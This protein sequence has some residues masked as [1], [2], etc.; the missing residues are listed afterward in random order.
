[1]G[2]QQVLRVAACVLLIG[3]LASAAPRKRE[4]ERIAIV[5]LGPT[6]DGVRGK[7]AAAVV[8]G[9]LQ[10]V[11]GD[12]V[13]DALAG[14]DGDKDAAALAAAMVEAKDKFGAL[15]CPEATA[16]AKSAIAIAAARQAAGIAVPELPR[17]WTYVL[18]CA[19]R[20]GDGA[21]AIEA[22]TRLREL[23]APDV[24]AKLLAKYP[25]FDVISNRDM[26][27]IEIKAEDGADVWVDFARAGKAPL[28]LAIATGPHV[29]AAALGTKRGVVTGTVIRK[30]PVVTIPLQDQ[31]GAWGS[32][33]A[34]VAAWH[35]NV[36]KASE[37]A[38]L[39]RQVDAR[40]AIVRHGDTIEAWGHAGEGEP[41]RRMGGEDGVRKVAE[42]EQLVALAAD[43]IQTWSDRAPDPDQPLLTETK[44]E[45]RARGLVKDEEE[46]TRWW[47]Y[48]TIAGALV[49]GAVVIYAHDSASDTQR[50]E[51]KYP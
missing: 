5:D 20:T 7:L 27:E 1:M 30:Q 13:E 34:R 33:A 36:P 28:K 31:A 50:V 22:A 29:M 35:G 11:I 48:A 44:E 41:V 32:L 51:L 40:V 2:P 37:I 6:D 43:R 9:G 16:A 45:R 38:W 49:A 47:V 19:D 25:A 4:H 17:A 10:P 21:A 26:I 39:L 12:G 8:A 46:P 42:A 24:D 18:L 15:A 14:I 3:G 23:G